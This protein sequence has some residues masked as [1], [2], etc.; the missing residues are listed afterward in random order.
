M[1]D[2][3]RGTIHN[4]LENAAK[5]V[6]VDGRNVYVAGGFYSTGDTLAS[7]IAM[8]DGMIWNALGEG[9]DDNVN[10]L[11]MDGRGHLYAGGYF[12]HAGRKPANQVARW[13]GKEWLP[14]G[15][16]VTGEVHT[17]AVDLMGNVYVGGRINKAGNIDATGSPC[18][19]GKIGNRWQVA[20]PV[21]IFPE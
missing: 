16:G 1:L 2:G 9:L 13:D 10:A 20:C 17:L 19:M 3:N 5:A 14:L 18:G 8:W 4:E 15:G 12:Q 6:V 7:H 11:A 21:F